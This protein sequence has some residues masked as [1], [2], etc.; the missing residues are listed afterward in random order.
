MRREDLL[1]HQPDSRLGHRGR[2]AL[3]EL[4]HIREDQ[5]DTGKLKTSMVITATMTGIGEEHTTRMSGGK[6]KVTLTLI[7][8]GRPQVI[9]DGSAIP[10]S[11]RQQTHSPVPLAFGCAAGIVGAADQ[12]AIDK[13]HTTVGDLL[14]DLELNG[15]DRRRQALGGVVIQWVRPAVTRRRTRRVGHNSANGI[16]ADRHVAGGGAHL[17]NSR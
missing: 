11:D 4:A 1:D 14:G 2:R 7:L 8:V 9:A 6:L 17:Q 3:P 10:V 16:R 5:L 15:R 12:G 13:T